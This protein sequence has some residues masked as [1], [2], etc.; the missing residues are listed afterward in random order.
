MKP[1]PQCLL[2]VAATCINRGRSMTSEQR[3]SSSCPRI[4]FHCGDCFTSLSVVRWILEV[5]SSSLGHA[6]VR[7]EAGIPRHHSAA[8]VCA[9]RCH[10]AGWCTFGSTS[11]SHI[12]QS[13]FVVST[14]DATENTYRKI[15]AQIRHAFAFIS[16]I[17]HLLT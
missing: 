15:M 8:M 7:T 12:R 16:S 13:A 9:F 10:I 5:P 4:V 2:T 11:H 1:L 14:T 6:A 3:E 17:Q